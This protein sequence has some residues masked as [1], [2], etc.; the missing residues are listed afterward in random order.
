VL[1]ALSLIILWGYAEV[2]YWFTDES[3]LATLIGC[4]IVTTDI[5]L[6][7]YIHANLSERPFEAV[8]IALMCRFSLLVFSWAWFIGYCVLFIVISLLLMNDILNKY[9]PLKHSAANTET[10]AA[11]VSRDLTL[12]AEFVLGVATTIFI[13]ITL[14]IYFTDPSGIHLTTLDI[15]GGNIDM[16][17]I[18]ICTIVLLLIVFMVLMTYRI[19]ERKKRH[20]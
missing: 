14:I 2:V 15:A 13:L 7:F 11:E 17:L 10:T 12:T 20:L 18:G 4:C 19:W 6:Y 3:W 9:Y 1:Y 8:L 16:W 5:I